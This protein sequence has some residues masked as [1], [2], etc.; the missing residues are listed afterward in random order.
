MD[1]NL[2]ERLKQLKIEDY[3]WIIYIG[4]IGLSLYSNN[5]E[6]HY[7]IFKDKISKELYQK[8]ITIIF[9]IAVIVYIYFVLDNYKDYQKAK[10]EDNLKK[11]KYTYLAF[12]ASFLT[13]IS[14]AIFLYIAAND[15]EIDV[16]LA[17]G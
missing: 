10:E 6:R 4:I 15:K 7:L 12:I 9:F 11:L 16:E 17:F 2:K 5:V 1:N 8:L 13:L 14:G 3:I